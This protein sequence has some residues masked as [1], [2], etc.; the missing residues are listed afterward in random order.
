[1]IPVRNIYYMMAY[2]FRLLDMK[3]FR[4]MDCEDFEHIEDLFAAI[5][6][7]G[8]SL[9]IKRGLGKE[10]LA[11]EAS[12]STPKGKVRITESIKTNSLMKMQ[13]VCSYDEFTEN[14]YM[15]QILKSS[16]VLLLK[17]NIS[18]SQKKH[19]RKLLHYFNNV[20]EV[21]LYSVDWKFRFHRNNSIYRPLM[22][23]CYLLVKGFLQSSEDGRRRLEDYIDDQTMPRLYEKFLLEYFRKEH[24]ECKA[25]AS[26]INWQLD[27]GYDFM[28]PNMRSD[29]TLSRTIDGIEHV[30]IIDAKYYTHNTAR[31]YESSVQK[32]I[33]GNLYQ[34]FTYV[35]N[36]E[37]EYQTNG[38]E[39]TVNGM[40]LYAKTDEDVQ[41]DQSY[42][43][44]GN[45]I[46]VKVLD[47][48]QRFEIIR[49]D[50]DQIAEVCFKTT[51]HT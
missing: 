15:N 39:H 19:I 44:S 40:L 48:S 33:S 23:I 4:D 51:S 6:E 34:I 20:D 43:M 31:S 26:K 32:V 21:D 42:S 27:D 10:Y 13:L 17:T 1:M 29:I 18:K 12:I 41:P 47:L 36:M 24:P 28:L 46:D 5:L 14:A 25:N 45:R 2:A 22:N 30:L 38:T 50:L 49:N 9:L 35:K 11:R 7:K 37:I 16:L 8:I 3:Q